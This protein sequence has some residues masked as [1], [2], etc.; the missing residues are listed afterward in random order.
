MAR[1]TPNGLARLTI[2]Q[3]VNLIRDLIG[4]ICDDDDEATILELVRSMDST[5]MRQ[6]V[7]ELGGGDAQAGIDFLDSGVDGEEWSTLSTLLKREPEL[8]KLL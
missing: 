4:G 8:A 1:Q 5:K 6:V 3:G 7:L 2:T